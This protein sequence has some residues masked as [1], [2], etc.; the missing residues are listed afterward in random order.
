MVPGIKYARTAYHTLCKF[1]KKWGIDETYYAACKA[2][3]QLFNQ[4]NSQ[5]TYFY[6]F[7]L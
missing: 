7:K 2:E 4:S 1:N 3:Y 5:L 6:N